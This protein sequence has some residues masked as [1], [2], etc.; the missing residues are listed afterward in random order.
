[1]LIGLFFDLDG[2]LVDSERHHWRAWRAALLPLNI[3]LS[4]SCGLTTA[5]YSYKS[6]QSLQTLC[7]EEH[8]LRTTHILVLLEV[9]PSVGR[10][11]LGP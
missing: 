3:K 2:T 1:M 4:F 11:N 10:S 8:F 6:A 5:L 9:Q 7:C